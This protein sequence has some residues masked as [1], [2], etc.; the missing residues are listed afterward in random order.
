MMENQTAQLLLQEKQLSLKQDFIL[1]Q[2]EEVK[3]LSGLVD[4]FSAVIV[5]SKFQASEGTLPSSDNQNPTSMSSNYHKV[6]HSIFLRSIQ[7]AA[8]SLKPLKP[9]DKKKSST[10][11]ELWDTIRK[12]FKNANENAENSD[13]SE[14]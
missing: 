12:K 6:D 9:D 11:S 14:S 13:E 7:V 8:A 1:L 10:H 2:A 3:L 4:D 5:S